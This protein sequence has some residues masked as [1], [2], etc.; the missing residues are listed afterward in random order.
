MLARS[1]VGRMFQKGQLERPWEQTV[2]VAKP[3]SLTMRV[4]PCQPPP[5]PGLAP[6]APPPHADSSMAGGKGSRMLVRLSP[7]EIA[8]VLDT[9]CYL[10]DDVQK[11]AASN[12]CS[13]CPA[14]SALYDPLLGEGTCDEQTSGQLCLALTGETVD[15]DAM[16]AALRVR[17]LLSAPHDKMIATL[18]IPVPSP[19]A[20]ELLERLLVN[21]DIRLGRSHTI[22]RSLGTSRPVFC[23]THASRMAHALCVV[24]PRA[25]VA[26]IRAC[27][28]R[29]VDVL[30]VRVLRGRDSDEIWAKALHATA[31][32]VKQIVDAA[33]KGALSLCAPRPESPIPGS[34][35]AGPSC[36]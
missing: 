29:S 9:G 19:V 21:G 1:A 14:L 15:S 34:H 20:F 31:A 30:R 8:A 13:A 25:E 17:T 26:P 10:L 2:A 24:G 16:I 27:L 32:R 36:G 6:L 22:D 23:S 7:V 35:E 18:S 33:L 12:G 4:A 28:P 3:A 5:L 11:W